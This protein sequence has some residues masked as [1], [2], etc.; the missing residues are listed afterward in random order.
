MGPIDAGAAV[1]TAQARRARRTRL[2]QVMADYFALQLRFAD[3]MAHLTGTPIAEAVGLYTNFHKRF[4][5][6]AIGFGPSPKAWDRLVEGVA[7][8]PG[9]ADRLDWTLRCYVEAPEDR[10]PAY[11]TAFG[12][13]SCEAPDESGVVRIH[14]NNLDSADGVGPLSRAKMGARRAELA[15]MFGFLRAQHPRAQSVQGRSWLYHLDA[16][17]R[18]FPAAYGDSRAPPLGPQ[19]YNGASNWGQMIDH[20]GAIKPAPRDFMLGALADLD[21]AEPWRAFPLPALATAAPISLFHQAYGL[22]V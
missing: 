4:G 12:C 1:E 19:R 6:G 20:R 16:Y 9:L 5:F 8:R 18:L 11:L 15:A 17:R 14:F 10:P 2:A 7:A 3:R 22:D 13:F 21:P